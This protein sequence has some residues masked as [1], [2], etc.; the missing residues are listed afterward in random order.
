[1]SVVFWTEMQTSPNYT[2]D[3]LDIICSENEG[4]R[5][6]G[7]QDVEDQFYI[8]DQSQD[9]KKSISHTDRYCHWPPVCYRKSCFNWTLI[10][11]HHYLLPGLKM[12]MRDGDLVDNY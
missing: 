8:S 11:D 1:M 3:R 10:S 5:H 7:L 9:E 4:Q 2:R 6:L 12:L